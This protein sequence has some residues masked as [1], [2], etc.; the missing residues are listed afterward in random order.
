MKTIKVL[1]I[2][3]LAVSIVVAGVFVYL[4]KNKGSQITLQETIRQRD[5]LEIRKFSDSSDLAVQY[6]S[7][8]KSSYNEK[9]PVSVYTA[10]SNQYEVD[11]R[12][13]NV[14]QFGPSPAVLAIG[15]GTARTSDES[16]ALSPEELE[17]K[18]REFISSHTK[19]QVNKLTPNHGNKD[20][21]YFFRWEDWL[22]KTTEGYSFIQIGYSQGGMLVSY[23]NTF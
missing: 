1:L 9:V 19:I 20:M 17:A 18:A 13:G 2:V 3:F 10:G 21:N 23:V 14:I 16:G 8:S 6:E 5:I 12:T 11:A 15:D 4:K 22:Q 7:E